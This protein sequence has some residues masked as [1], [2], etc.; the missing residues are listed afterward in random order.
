MKVI[1]PEIDREVAK[2]LEKV[3]FVTLIT[4]TSNRKEEKMLPVLARCFDE[5][6]GTQTFKLAVNMI[7]NEKSA[8]I[9]HNLMG[10]GSAWKVTEKVVAF[11]ADNCVTN[12]GKV[13][14]NGD[15]NVFYRLKQELGRKIVG[16]GCV[17]HIIHNGFDAACD[18]LPI[19]IEGIVVNLYKYF[20]IHTLRV[21]S[22]KEFCDEASVEY[23]KLTNHSGTRFLTLAPA[24][25]KV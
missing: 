3:K 23:V 1:S 6:K 19:N 7:S 25:T 8:T 21:E 9:T 24:V 16:V 17:D 5:V 2:S 15:N 22:L 20:H 4:D 13:N 10:T 11:G 18:Q 12:F 14:R